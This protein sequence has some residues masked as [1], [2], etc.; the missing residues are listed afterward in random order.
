MSKKRQALDPDNPV[1]KKLGINALFRDLDQQRKQDI[2]PQSMKELG[3]KLQDD[4]QQWRDKHKKELKNGNT[5]IFHPSPRTVADILEK[6]L[7]YGIIANDDEE[8]ERGQVSFYDLDSGTYK[9]SQRT[10]EKL[11][12][13]IERS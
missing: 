10:L 13:C 8:M 1:V 6:Y 7:H 11:A 3:Q 12:T 4:G 5:K 9:A 2:P